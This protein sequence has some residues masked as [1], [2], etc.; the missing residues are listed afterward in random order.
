MQTIGVLL[1]TQHSGIL[2]DIVR[3]IVA[4]DDALSLAGELTSEADLAAALECT[5][6]A[7]I[8]WLADD[9]APTELLLDRR[10]LRVVTVEDDGRTGC[11]WE[12]R[13]QLRELGALSPER[14]VAAL[15]GTTGE[16]PA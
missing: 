16:S 2:T 9:I 1:V 14:L 7:A 8:V 5:G 13:P 15:R 12:M 6:A 4:G 11:L 3:G 10:R